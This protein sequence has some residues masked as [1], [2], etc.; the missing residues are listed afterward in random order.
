[1]FPFLTLKS[2]LKRSYFESLEDIL[3]AAITVMKAFLYGIQK[4][5]KP[6]T[7]ADMRVYNEELYN[8]YASPIIIIIIIIIIRAVKSRRMRWRDL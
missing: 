1:M 8:L 4:C 6:V 3:L 2:S 7:S 5:S